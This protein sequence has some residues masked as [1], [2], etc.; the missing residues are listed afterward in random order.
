MNIVD[1]MEAA[2]SVEGASGTVDSEGLG[3]P[4]S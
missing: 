4:F 3:F 2:D 1:S